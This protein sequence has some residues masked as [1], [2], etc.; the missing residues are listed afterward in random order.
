MELPEIRAVV[1]SFLSE[2][3]LCAA[4]RVCKSWQTSFAPVLYS[5]VDLSSKDIRKPG[6][7]G[8]VR[9]ARF[10]QE[11]ILG[12]VY[13]KSDFQYL[14]T[15]KRLL[16]PAMTTL[17]MSF[18]SQF[19]EF[20][21]Q[22][23]II[24]KCPQLKS[25]RWIY[26]GKSSS[27]VSDVCNLFKTSCPFVES[28][29][30]RGITFADGDA[31]QIL[32]GCHRITHFTLHHCTFGKS[33]FRSL[34]R[35]FTY[36]Q[37]LTL[38]KCGGVPS[39]MTQAI[40]THCPNLTRISGGSLNA[41]DIIDGME[42][43]SGGWICTNLERIDIYIY[44]FGDKPLEWHRKV[45]QQLSRMQKL[46]TIGLY[47]TG[48]HDGLAFRVEAGLNLLSNLKGMKHLTIPKSEHQLEEQDVRWMIKEWP[49]ID[50]VEGEMND[51]R[52]TQ[53]LLFKIL[54]ENGVAY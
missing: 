34:A 49:N 50:T 31:S 40:L 39:K 28:L 4:A 12:K 41:Q 33:A 2:P 36:L 44:G 26:A 20:E 32:D 11:L 15:D 37:D 22:V 45:F 46:N 16:F 10:I 42:D 23:E 29:N 38:Y 18:G 48:Q 43:H 52:E 21:D 27:Q 54:N 25:L 5:A 3:D 1:A 19:P 53:Q 51:H 9:Y 17:Y 8:V 6:K 13:Y 30:I 14:F 24:R 7:D 35:H 47:G